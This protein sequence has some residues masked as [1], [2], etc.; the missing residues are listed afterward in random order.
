MNIDILVRSGKIIMWL[1]QNEK[2]L[3]ICSHECLENM[4]NP[5]YIKS[6]SLKVTVRFEK[7]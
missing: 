4:S 3:C 6:I 1:E 5:I 2:W 7:E